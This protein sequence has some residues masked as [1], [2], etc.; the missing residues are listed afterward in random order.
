M[1]HP[2]TFHDPEG[3]E[4]PDADSRAWV[5]ALETPGAVG[6]KAQRDLHLL[7][8][9]AARDE[10]RRS[11]ARLTGLQGGQLDDYAHDSADRAL[12]AVRSSL[13]RYLGGSRFTTWACKFAIRA[14][15][16]GF[17]DLPSATDAEL[18]CA[19]CF[20]VLDVYV[21]IEAEGGA[22]EAEATIPR[23]HSHLNDCPACAADHASLLELVE[24]EP[25]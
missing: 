24:S 2:M 11:R 15:A 22:T 6:E 8:L 25:R 23:V 12:T 5:T 10:I 1:F 13:D 9:G 20:G 18:S 4:G 14:A 19:Q 17:R 3:H 21:E 16:A 7:L